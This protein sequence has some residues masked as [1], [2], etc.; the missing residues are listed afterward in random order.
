MT[1]TEFLDW[2]TPDGSNR[3]ELVDGVPV[4]IAP[5]LGRHALIHAEASRLIGNHLAERRPDCRALIEPGVRP[6]DRNLR[7]P[8]L[9]VDCGEAA[10][11]PPVLIVEILSP[12]NW[13]RNRD[14]VIRYTTMQ[15]VAEVLVLHQDRVMAE[16]MRRGTGG[17]WDEHLLL[18]DGD[19]LKL[20]S[21]GLTAPLAAFYRTAG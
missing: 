17:A 5:A 21:I 4:P 12:S 2:P 19:M 6:D 20:A 8:A 1:V 7:I 10:E 3:W 9:V 14:N 11:R 18:I 13:R 16:V 15:G